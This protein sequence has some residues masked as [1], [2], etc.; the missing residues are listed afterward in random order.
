MKRKRKLYYD[1]PI[2]VRV[3]EWMLRYLQNTADEEGTTV[4]HIVRRILSSQ[5]KPQRNEGQ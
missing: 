1:I 3:P 2:Q 4:S 5:M